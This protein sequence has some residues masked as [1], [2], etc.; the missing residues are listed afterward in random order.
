MIFVNKNIKNHKYIWWK[1]KK[2]KCFKHYIAKCILQFTYEMWFVVAF[3]GCSKILLK[4][5]FF[6]F[7]I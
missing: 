3:H 4:C 1:R 2:K 7:F 6:D 5:F